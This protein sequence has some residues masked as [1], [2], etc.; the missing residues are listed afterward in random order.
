MWIA[1]NQQN[2]VVIFHQDFVAS[3]H[4]GICQGQMNRGLFYWS[5][6]SG[7]TWLSKLEEE[8]FDI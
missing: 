5:K 6:Q 1:N 3:M 7:E 8:E 4:S 2:I